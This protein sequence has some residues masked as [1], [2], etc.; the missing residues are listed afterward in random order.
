MIRTKEE[1]GVGSMLQLPC[2]IGQD[3]RPWRRRLDRRTRPAA[4]TN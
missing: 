3:V 4:V 1:A 2:W